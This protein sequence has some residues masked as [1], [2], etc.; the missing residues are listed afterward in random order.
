MDNYEMRPKP[1]GYRLSSRQEDDK[2]ISRFVIGDEEFFYKGMSDLEMLA[3]HFIKRSYLEKLAELPRMQ[4]VPDHGF[5]MSCKSPIFISHTW[6]APNRPDDSILNSIKSFIPNR[7]GIG[8]W[9]DYCCL[10][11]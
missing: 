9:I 11:Q 1:A 7:E 10:P 5:S 2:A 3:T 4:E 8:I 6:L